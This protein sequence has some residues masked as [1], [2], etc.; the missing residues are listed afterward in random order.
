LPTV[1]HAVVGKRERR[2]AERV[3]VLEPASKNLNE[4]R[5]FPLKPHDTSDLSL[6]L[7]ARDGVSAVSQERHSREE[8][9]RETARVEVT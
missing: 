4:D 3:G 8:M 7:T 6:T 5:V 2:L 9:A 1:A